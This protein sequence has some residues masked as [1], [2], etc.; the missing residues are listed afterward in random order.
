MRHSTE[1]SPRIL[2]VDRG[3][4]C[5]EKCCE[6][7]PTIIASVIPT[8]NGR[9][10]VVSSLEAVSWSSHPPQLFV[11]R[12]NSEDRLYRSKTLLKSIKKRWVGVPVIGICCEPHFD[13]NELVEL[14]E[15]GL[16]DYV[17]CPWTEPDLIPRLCRALNQQAID[18]KKASQPES[19]LFRHD[20]LVGQSPC[21]VQKISAIGRLANADATVLVAGETGTGKELFAQAIH[22]NSSRKTKPFIPVNCSALPDQLFENELFGHV[23]GA[24]THASTAQVGLVE[25]AEGGTLFLDEVDSLTP[26]AQTKLLRLLQNGEFRPLGSPKS[27]KA[28]VRVIAATNADLKALVAAKQFREDLY[29]RLNVLTVLVPPLRERVDDIPLLVDHFLKRHGANNPV[30]ATQ[31]STTALERLMSYSWPGNVRELEGVI[32]R[33]LTLADSSCLQPEDFDIFAKQDASSRR[34]QGLAEAKSQVVDEFE[35]SYLVNLLSRSHGN[36][37]HAAKAAGKERRTF[38]RLLKKHSLT[39]VAFRNSPVIP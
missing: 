35:H 24:Y 14:L 18:G 5:V 26:V 30:V 17:C 6:Q 11:L 38:Q 15:D 8:L 20:A 32:Q 33:A 27:R 37:S 13:A 39:G 1:L 29:Y 36:I 19:P 4:P 34:N 23:K 12:I 21:F 10:E 7:L 2:I 25:E 22:F 28:D 3:F 31:C 9:Q 16:D